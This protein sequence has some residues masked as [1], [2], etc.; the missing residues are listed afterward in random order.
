MRVP[1]SPEIQLDR[2]RADNY[3]VLI[4]RQNPVFQCSNHQ[5]PSAKKIVASIETEQIIIKAPDANIS[6]YYCRIVKL[7]H[8]SLVISNLRQAK[9]ALHNL[10]K[11]RVQRVLCVG[12][13]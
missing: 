13:L 2:L 3:L 1:S 12:V 10:F 7:L 5:Q 11:Q 4:S 9:I 8:Q 6:I